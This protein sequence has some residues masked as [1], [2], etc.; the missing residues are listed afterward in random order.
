MKR[1]INY[2]IKAEY[3]GH[4]ISAFL[5]EKSYPESVLTEL[6]KHEGSILINDLPVH[7]NY[8][9][10]SSQDTE[11]LTVVIEDTSES[12]N[13]I[14]IKMP[15]NIVYEDDDILV[16]NKPSG[17]PIHPSLNNYENTLA[18]AVTYYY[19]SQNLPF[20]F[21]CIN[22]LDKDTTG[23]TIIAKHSLAAGILSKDMSNRKIKREYT[24]IVEGKFD[25]DS[26]RIDLPIG[27]EGT[28]LITRKI[29]YQNGEPA[30]TSYQVVSYN[31]SANLS[32]VKLKL[33]TGRTHQIRVHMKAIG[34]PLIGDY[35]YNPDNKLM[36]RQ[37]LHAGRI[38]FTH[39]IKR[40][41]LSFEV[42]LPDDM[43]TAAH[44]S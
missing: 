28:S 15:L 24:T 44:F 19:E 29:D 2:E 32:L 13:I 23:L 33:E 26:G 27:R 12:P 14:P 16:I 42:P 31:Q 37:A 6:R 5:K 25:Q 41:L 10:L 4:K 18:N 3:K 43:K 36:E 39:P 21:R 11:T 22:R 38:E 30:I 20:V 34:H 8:V 9:L 1:I 40:I 35:L 17:M 7:M